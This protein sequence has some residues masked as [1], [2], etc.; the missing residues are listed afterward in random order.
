MDPFIG[1][2]QTF[3]FNFPPRGWAFCDGQLLSIASNTALFSLLG[4]TFGGDGRTTFGLPDLRGRTALH[5]GTGPGLSP[6][7]WGQRGGVQNSTLTTNNMPSHNHAVTLHGTSTDG[8]QKGPDGHIL[9]AV[10]DGHPYSN[11][12]PNVTAN[13]SSVTTANA[14]GGQ[15][16]ENRDPYLGI[17]HCIALTGIFPSR[18]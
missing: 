12:T 7:T 1:Q 13:A 10:E 2:I 11:A 18:N 15:A 16:F 8:N 5:A 9:A 6:V 4:T 14:G 3:G 17:Y